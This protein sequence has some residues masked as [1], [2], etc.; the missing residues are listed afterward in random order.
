MV[1]LCVVACFVLGAC[2]PQPKPA[3]DVN[4]TAEQ[5]SRM[6]PSEFCANSASL[7]SH[8]WFTPVQQAMVFERMRNA[9]CFGQPQAQPIIIR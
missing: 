8:P 2:T 5:W 7:A 6:T 9:G 3:W 1:R 4:F